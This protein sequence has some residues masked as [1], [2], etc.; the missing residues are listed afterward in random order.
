MKARNLL[1]M[2][3]SALV[4]LIM[5][6]G[7]ALAAHGATWVDS[8]CNDS[9]YTKS[10]WK[11]SEAYSYARSAIGDGYEWG[12]GCWNSNGYDDT[13]SWPVDSGG[14]GPDCSGLVFKV[15]AL[16]NEPGAN[17]LKFRYR[18]MLYKYHGPY[19]TTAFKYPSGEPKFYNVS[20]SNLLSMDALVS[21]SHII[22]YRHDSDSDG[23][24][25]GVEARSNS[26]GTGVWERW[27]IYSSQYQATRRA[28]WTAEC[29]PQCV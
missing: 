15:W 16:D 21:D 7:V 20:K 13:P 1:T 28:G 11:R 12:G 26:L 9:W 17:V 3:G 27:N 29:Y 8:H 23:L 6:M 2:L 18:Y 4:T 10:T 19:N 14:E 25:Y 22:L 5:L 24:A